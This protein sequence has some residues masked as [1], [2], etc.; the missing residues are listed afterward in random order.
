MSFKAVCRN[1]DAALLYFLRL[2]EFTTS[3]EGL[4]LTQSKSGPFI[5]FKKQ[6]DGTTIGAIVV[7]LDDCVLAGEKDFIDDM[8][9][10]LRSEFG[11]VE[12]GKLRKLLDVRYKWDDLKD[13]NK[14]RVTLYMED[15]ANKI[16][17][18]CE[19]ATTGLTPRVQKTSGKLGEVL[20]KHEGEPEINSEYR[21]VLGK[22]IFY[23][24]KVS[25]E[26]SYA[27]GQLACQIH[28]LN[29][30]HWK[31][32]GRII[33]YVRGRQKHEVVITRP[34]CMRIVSFGDTSYG[35]CIEIR[36]SATGDIHTIGRSLV[37]WWA[38][39]TK[40]VC[41]SSAEV[42]YVALTEMSK[43]QKFLS[44]LLTEMF[45][46]DLPCILY[47]CNEAVVYLATNQ[48]VSARTKRI[49]I[50]E[51]H[52]REHLKEL[53]EVRPIESENNFADILTKNVKV[54]MLE[55]LATALLNGF[56]GYHDG[57]RF[58]KHQRENI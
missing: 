28:N 10:K 23:V 57:F 47:E 9:D 19:Q 38:Q 2:V 53:G 42:E 54:T 22:L 41:L 43:E 35:D 56:D 7:Y 51:H 33:G 29:K 21:T 5:F 27:C 48:H 49:D 31:A 12:E 44:V 39:K 26:C 15:K 55:R 1:I 34:K 4:G 40:F 3:V 18:S 8:K 25:P 24:T 16:I 37:S 30:S 13:E 20:M 11:V 58:T 32:V 46:C 14:A 50:S 52:V 45:I 6:A 36:R 17:R